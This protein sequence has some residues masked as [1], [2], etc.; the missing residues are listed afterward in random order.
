MTTSNGSV[1]PP[2]SLRAAAGEVA[3]L[4]AARNETVA[5]AETAAG[6]LI[7]ASIL[8][9][10]GASK[11]YRGG[12]TVREGNLRRVASNARLFSQTGIDTL[13]TRR[14]RHSCTPSSRASLSGAGHRPTSRTTGARPPRSSP[15]SRRTCARSWAAR[16]H[17]AR[18][19]RPAPR[20]ARHGTERREPFPPFFLPSRLPFRA[21]S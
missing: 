7:S 9:T 10:P 13:P 18:A 19:G 4:L 15:A 14:A 2:A 16:T 1:F 3:S 21:C 11:I 12:L 17:C 5:V 8:A 20:E 6:G